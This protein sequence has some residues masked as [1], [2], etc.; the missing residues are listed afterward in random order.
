VASYFSPSPLTS[1]VGSLGADVSMV[2]ANQYYD[3]PSVVLTSGTWVLIAVAHIAGDA[4][5]GVATIRL[6]DGVTSVASAEGGVEASINL[7]GFSCIA[8]VTVP[9]AG[10]TYTLSA[11]ATQTLKTFKAAAIQDVT[12]GNNTS[13]IVA[14]KI[15]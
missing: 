10:A 14:L 6:W 11:R 3:G 5:A 8:R 4:N 2:N 12:L 1:V 13:R 15:A 9:A 7:T